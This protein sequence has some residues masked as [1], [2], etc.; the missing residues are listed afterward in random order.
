MGQLATALV[1]MILG[2]M[3]CAAYFYGSNFLLDKIFPTKNCP[4]NVVTKNLRTSNAIRQRLF[5]ALSLRP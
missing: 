4:A 3:G 2:V 1:T 5:L